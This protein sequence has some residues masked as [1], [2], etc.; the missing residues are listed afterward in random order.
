MKFSSFRQILICI[1]NPT[2]DDT[3]D[4]RIT[5]YPDKESRILRVFAILTGD[6]SHHSLDLPTQIHLYNAYEI[7][8]LHR[9]RQCKLHYAIDHYYAQYST[10]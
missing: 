8:R 3:V 2:L 4:N 7:D 6:I 1:I 5:N 9:T 10:L